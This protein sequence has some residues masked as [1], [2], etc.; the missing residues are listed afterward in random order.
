MVTKQA[1]WPGGCKHELR[2]ALHADT[3]DG[4][5]ANGTSQGQSK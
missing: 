2:Q 5:F 3:Q 1:C 4:A